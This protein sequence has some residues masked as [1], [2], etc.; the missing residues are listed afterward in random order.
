MDSA[1]RTPRPHRLKNGGRLLTDFQEIVIRRSRRPGFTSETSGE[2]LIAEVVKSPSL[3][4]LQKFL[5]VRMP[6]CGGYPIIH[7]GLGS[8]GAFDDLLGALSSEKKLMLVGPVAFCTASAPDRFF[9]CMLF[10][11]SG[12]FRVDKISPRPPE[13][14][15]L[16]L[17]IRLR[18]ERL[19]VLPN[20]TATWSGLI[21]RHRMLT[22]E[23]DFLNS[24]TPAQLEISDCSWKGF[25]PFPLINYT[26]DPY[27]NCKI[28]WEQFEQRLKRYPF[29]GLNPAERELI[30]HTQI[31]KNFYWVWQF[32]DRSDLA[33]EMTIV[34]IR[35][36][37]NGDHE[38]GHF[39]F[40]RQFS[41]KPTPEW[42]SEELLRF[43]FSPYQSGLKSGDA[44]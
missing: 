9:H 39:E 11:L 24:F 28:D 25:F 42:I 8:Y 2:E 29:R 40:Y 38:I 31:E 4:T 20:L 1:K 5:D 44:D 13:L 12:L 35:Q 41:H 18:V 22:R 6:W 36:T 19:S 34:W 26:N 14:S 15:D 27:R 17:R 33:L 3:E 16:L 10:L 30:Y 43:E 32:R 23:G 37:S 7:G 21:N